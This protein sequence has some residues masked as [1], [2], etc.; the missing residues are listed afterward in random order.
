MSE[1][2]E[3]LCRRCKTVKPLDSFSPETRQ[4]KKRAWCLGRREECK[5]CTAEMVRSWRARNSERLRAERKL[6]YS[7]DAAFRAGELK[8]AQER[9]A[10]PEIHQR[11]RQRENAR[12][13]ANPTLSNAGKKLRRALERGASGGERVDLAVVALRDNWRCHLCGSEV[14]KT[15][16]SLDHLV[17]V[18]RGGLHTY[19]NVALAHFKCNARRGA[20]PIMQLE[21]L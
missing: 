18:S 7:T 12:R 6:R 1:P 5:Q 14:S 11:L 17:P 4:K 8:R 16:W 15:N 9:Y 13:R 2:V 3:R 19:A 21:A 10:N 20:K